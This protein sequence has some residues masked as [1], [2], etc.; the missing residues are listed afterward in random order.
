MN[1]TEIEFYADHSYTALESI[2]HRCTAAGME[3]ALTHGAEHPMAVENLAIANAAWA[4]MQRRTFA[5]PER[6]LKPE[7]WTVCPRCS[8][9]NDI[10]FEDDLREDGGPMTGRAKC[11]NCDWV[12]DE[13]ETD[14][15]EF[16][17]DCS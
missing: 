4:E 2:V 16:D 10:V 14:P 5:V 1:P 6:N 15:P 8:A 3:I 9:V 17:G 12:G 7:T 11:N 13:S